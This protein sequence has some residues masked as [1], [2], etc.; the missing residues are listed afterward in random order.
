MINSNCALDCMNVATDIKIAGM[1]GQLVQHESDNDIHVTK[2]EKEKLKSITNDSED[3]S[4]LTEIKL[5]LNNKAD[6]NEIPTKLSQLENDTNFI[7]SIPDFY[8]TEEE[9]KLLIEGYLEDYD[10]SGGSGGAS[11]ED[12]KRLEQLIEDL[13]TLVNNNTT[14]IESI[15]RHLKNILK[16]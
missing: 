9:V 5:T 2:E 12:I 1:M 15:K 4:D 13:T 16:V 14:D 11:D 8:T 6:K 7:S 10:G 3:N